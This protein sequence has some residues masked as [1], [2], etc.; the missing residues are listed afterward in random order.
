MVDSKLTSASVLELFEVVNNASITRPIEGVEA[1][2]SPVAT[3]TSPIS[4][5]SPSR[6]KT[7]KGHSGSQFVAVTSPAC[8]PNPKKY[9]P[10]D[11][12]CHGT[13]CCE[14]GKAKVL[15]GQQVTWTNQTD[16]VIVS[17]EIKIDKRTRPDAR[18]SDTTWITAQETFPQLG[19]LALA[20][21]H[22]FLLIKVV[23]STETVHSRINRCSRIITTLLVFT[24]F[25]HPII[26]FGPAWQA[27]LR[28][29]L[30]PFCTVELEPTC[31]I[32]TNQGH[33]YV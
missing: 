6:V 21:S 11:P 17:P 8:G 16:L 12:C 2:T 26:I 9:L 23:L 10:Q 20:K 15:P 25:N 1:T 27:Q 4:S 7:G 30:C 32:R 29:V 31:S 22:E 13:G 24:V 18:N 19:F 5:S 14:D 28:Y 33:L 3:S